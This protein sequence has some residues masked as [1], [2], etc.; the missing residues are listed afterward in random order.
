MCGGLDSPL[1]TSLIS[2]LT[3]AISFLARQRTASVF[4]RWPKI[5]WVSRL[6]SSS[7]RESMETSVELTG[8]GTQEEVSLA[9]LIR[10]TKNQSRTLSQADA[11]IGGEG[12]WRRNLLFDVLAD[13]PLHQ[14]GGL[15]PGDAHHGLAGGGAVVDVH[16]VHDDGGHCNRAQE[17]VRTSEDG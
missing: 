15:A 6:L 16:Q 11:A 1:D 5:T 10:E 4:S 3:A 14:G 9:Q 17:G 7:K 2:L 12:G 13:E 8:R